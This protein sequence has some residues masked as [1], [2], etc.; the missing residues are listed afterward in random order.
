RRA[1]VVRDRT[2]RARYQGVPLSPKTY[3]SLTVG[4]NRY[5]DERPNAGA[6]LPLAA[7]WERQP[8]RRADP[9][10]PLAYGGA[11]DVPGHTGP[12]F[13]PAASGAPCPGPTTPGRY[14]S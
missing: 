1:W 5:C 7:R 4:R 9:L 13:V 6:D 8:A 10:L 3:M 11:A 12:G 2:G 14:F